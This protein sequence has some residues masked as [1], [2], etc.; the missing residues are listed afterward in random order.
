MSQVGYYVERRLPFVADSGSLVGRRTGDLYLV[1][2]RDTT[3]AWS[4]GEG[5]LTILSGPLPPV[6]SRHRQALRHTTRGVR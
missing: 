6:A 1:L 3:I 4:R 5:P 2:S